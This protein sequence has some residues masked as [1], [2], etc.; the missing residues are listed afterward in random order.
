MPPENHPCDCEAFH[1]FLKEASF[2]LLDK[3]VFVRHSSLHPPCSWPISSGLVGHL[4]QC[5]APWIRT[6]FLHRGQPLLTCPEEPVWVPY[7][8]FSTLHV[9]VYGHLRWAPPSC[10]VFTGDVPHVSCLLLSTFSLS[11]IPPLS[12][13]YFV[14]HLQMLKAAFTRLASLS[15][16]LGLAPLY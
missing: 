13:R 7:D 1:S 11:A 3:S 6:A 8:L 5:K 10:G 2:P 4:L 12:L 14:H 15:A 16:R 9:F